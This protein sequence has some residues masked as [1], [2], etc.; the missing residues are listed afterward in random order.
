MPEKE[1]KSGTE[2]LLPKAALINL[3][4]ITNTPHHSVSG[5]LEDRPSGS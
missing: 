3:A 4:G 5:L 2:Q 1:R